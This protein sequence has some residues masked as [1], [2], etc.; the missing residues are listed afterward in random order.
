MVP[1]A[2]STDEELMLLYRDGDAGA[3]DVLYA[4]HKG[5]VYRYR[6]AS[7]GMRPR[8]RSCSRTYG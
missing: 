4:R 8:P 7:A 1:G 6:C 3:F 5:G 2:E